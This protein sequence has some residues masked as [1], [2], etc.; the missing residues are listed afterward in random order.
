MSGG[1]EDDRPGAPP[2]GRPGAAG[3][4]RAGI[5]WLRGLPWP[6]I[7]LAAVI[8]T[9]G[10]AVFAYF[11]LP[12]AW[13][14]GAMA[15]TTVAAIGGARI[16]MPDR[17]RSTLI[18][19]LGVFL[20]GAFTP[21]IVS[22]FGEWTV[23]LVALAFYVSIA[24]LTVMLFLRRV[25]GYDRA[26]AYFSAAPG[27][28]GEML[29]AGGELGA[30]TRKLA[31]MHATRVLLV[32]FVLPFWFRMTGD[33]QPIDK[34][35]PWDTGDIHPLDAVLLI[36][37]AIFGALL[38][39]RLHFPAATLTGPMLLSA[40]VH[41]MG[42][43]ESRPPGELVALAQVVLG[44]SVGCRFVGTRANEVLR[45]AAVGVA[46]TVILLS[47]TTLFSL[48]LSHLTDLPQAAIVLAFAPGGLAEMSLVA[49]S[50]NIDTA[51]IAA[52]HVC[53]IA[54]VVAGARLGF[55]ALDRWEKR[56]G[57]A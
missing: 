26:T 42:W 45:M 23:S 27:G 12:L 24:T 39:K 52:H 3:R 38:G 53:R 54:L 36:G 11:R 33:Y 35:L 46:I 30:D 32:V 17:F 29:I 4:R 37:C 57:G 9:A 16:A 48:L 40:I 19:I 21:D 5:A 22:R 8:G 1:G 41:L 25:M 18:V 15:F 34:A 28:F 50:L 20:G 44:T 47:L 10:G 51:Y 13:M 55:A 43:T 7:V 31:L 2:G 56:R 49:L 14:L 6:R